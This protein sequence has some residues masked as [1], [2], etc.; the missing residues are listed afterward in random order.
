MIDRVNNLQNKE[1]GK[2]VDEK[3]MTRYYM[4]GNELVVESVRVSNRG[5]SKNE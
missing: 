4:R 5:G 1:M 2:S 3:E